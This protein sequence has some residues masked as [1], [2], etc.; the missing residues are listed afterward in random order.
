MEYDSASCERDAIAARPS[1][2]SILPLVFDF[3]HPQS[4]VDVGCGL[5]TWLAVAEELGVSDYVGVDGFTGEGELLIP[6]SSFVRRDLTEPLSL[7]RTF[8]LAICLEVAEHLPEVAAMTLVR[9]LVQL[10]SVILFSAAIPGQ[11]GVNHINEQWPNYWADL[12]AKED[13]QPADQI[14]R[15][16]WNNPEVAWWY[17]QNVVLYVSRAK[18]TLVASEPTDSHLLSLVHPKLFELRRAWLAIDGRPAQHTSCTRPGLPGSP[19][20]SPKLARTR[21]LGAFVECI[22]QTPGR[23]RGLVRLMVSHGSTVQR[24]AYRTALTLL[25]STKSRLRDNQ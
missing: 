3:L 11:G 17:S 12:F 24:P 8:D 13:Y 20:P 22:C 5:G 16:V 23:T 1:A 9:S 10:S 2:R 21:N 25:S 19:T 14:R 15:K 18:R 6:E 7:G 4:I